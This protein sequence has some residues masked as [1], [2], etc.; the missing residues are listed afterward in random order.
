MVNRMNRKKKT[1]TNWERIKRI[2]SGLE[3]IDVSEIPSLDKNFWKEASVVIPSGKTR[4]TI[5]IDTDIY[6]W[7]IAQE[8]SGY[9]TH[10]NAVLRSYVQAQMHKRS[11]TPIRVVR[12]RGY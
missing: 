10:I 5:R 3:P 2:R 6:R 1:D 4:I 11:K 8:A 7:F 12:A 9:Q